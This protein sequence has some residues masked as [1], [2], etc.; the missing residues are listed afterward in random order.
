[1]AA[2]RSRVFS[3][4]TFERTIAEKKP[5]PV[6]FFYGSEEYRIK[7]AVA[8]IKNRIIQEGEAETG[9][10]VYDFAETQF[11]QLHADIRTVSFF[12]SL[13]GVV[14]RNLTIES[15]RGEKS[16]PLDEDDQKRLIEYIKNPSPDV[17]LLL[18]TEKADMRKKFWKELAANAETVNFET[19]DQK[20]LVTE[21]ML[22]SSLQFDGESRRWIMENFE[23]S[24]PQLESE[25]QKLEVYLG[26]RKKVSLSDLEECMNAPRT[27]SVFKLTKAI[28]SGKIDESLQ[29]LNM[30]RIQ[31]EVLQMLMGLIA[32]QFRI[33]L[34]LKSLSGQGLSQSE[35]ARRCGVNP[36]FFNEYQQQVKN[37]SL[38]SLK[39]I[40]HK[41]SSTDIKLK[42]SS[43]DGW[44]I[45]EDTIISLM[46]G[47]Q[48][49]EK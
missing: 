37:F 44:M 45:L 8:A 26:G 31:G 40:L 1:M 18:I 42:S 22:E 24:C 47:R 4:K 41:L 39:S 20:Q 14:A 3:L 6:Y 35:L 7:R 32:R 15:G 36:Y 13:R 34:V 33:L 25:F 10:S 5:S 27:E 49:A 16:N 48:L 21:T 23:H 11:S 43:M 17:V 12:G 2:D 28:A 38:G 29:I 30:L 46:S 9:W 19:K